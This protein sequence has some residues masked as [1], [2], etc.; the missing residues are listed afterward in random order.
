MIKYETY[1]A[2]NY[3]Y[4]NSFDK[5]MDE[6]GLTASVVRMSDKMER[7]KSLTKKKAQVKDEYCRHS[8][9]F[10]NVLRNDGDALK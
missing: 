9:G 6:F 2:K 7:L 4:G 5:S 1:K 3:D 10:G 8:N